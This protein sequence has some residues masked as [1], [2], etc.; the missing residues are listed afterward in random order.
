MASPPTD[1]KKYTTKLQNKRILIIGGTSGI[2]YAVAEASLEH[3]SDVTISSSSQS[4]ITSA[5][6]RLQASYPSA[7]HR[8]HSH[9][10]DLS[11]PATAEANIAALFAAVGTDA[12]TGRKLDHVIFTAGDKLA[13]MPLSTITLERIQQAGMVRFVAPLLV[14]RY[15]IAHL[16][17]GPDASLTLTT[18][19]VAERPMADWSVVGSY[20][21]G[22]YGMVRG[23]ALDMRPV[24]VN[25]VAP[26]AVATEL[27]DAMPRAAYKE[28]ERR[29]GERLLTGRIGRVEDVAE[30]F[31]YAMRDGNL[32]GSVVGSN[33][34][35]LLV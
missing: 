12:A 31:V 10:C 25:L 32:T 30:A 2:G 29:T 19:S 15:C 22:L 18:G 24:R 11:A 28:F 23:L 26:G 4:R 34:G 3:G 21:A 33:G 35:G 17:A 8:L 14:A 20:A 27:W 13:T 9:A 6:S 7:T 16:S 5:I 1:A